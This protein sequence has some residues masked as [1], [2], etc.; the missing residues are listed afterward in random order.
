MSNIPTKNSILQSSF[1]INGKDINSNYNKDNKWTKKNALR[2]LNQKRIKNNKIVMQKKKE[3]LLT[4]GLWKC[5]HCDLQVKRLT[6]A[7]IGIPVYKIIDEILEQNP[8]END[9]TILD[10]MV[11]LKHEDIQIV[12]CCDKCNK[13]VDLG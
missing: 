3:C 8:N 4:K 13:L 1:I 2:E 6:C 5:P 7:H 12:I 9:I 11:Q 10:K